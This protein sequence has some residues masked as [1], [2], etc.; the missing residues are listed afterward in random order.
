MT[1]QTLARLLHLLPRPATP[2]LNTGNWD[3]VEAT[4]RTQLPD[5]YKQLIQSY[6][7]GIIRPANC[8]FISPFHLPL[9]KTGSFR[10]C[11]EQAKKNGYE[12]PFLVYPSPGGLLPWGGGDNGEVFAWLTGSTPAS[13]DTIAFSP[14]CEGYLWLRNTST[15]KCIADLLEGSSP[16]F[17]SF[18]PKTRFLQAQTFHPI[19]VSPEQRQTVA[20]Q[21]ITYNSD[22]VS[23]RVGD[24]VTLSVPTTWVVR[25]VPVVGSAGPDTFSGYFSAERSDPDSSTGAIHLDLSFRAANVLTDAVQLRNILRAEL[26]SKWADYVTKHEEAEAEW[27]R[28]VGLEDDRA[29][30]TRQADLGNRQLIIAKEGELQGTSFRI[31]WLLF[32]KYKH[33]WTFVYFFSHQGE[34]RLTFHLTLIDPTTSRPLLDRIADSVLFL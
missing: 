7:A 2:V 26:E 22:M 31:P 16:L 32:S 23:F 30:G 17:P 8:W 34:W 1:R 28:E 29:K 4:L 15:V 20:L 3:E 5:D 25:T 18:F 33:S 14:N 19:V 12:I 27:Y 11:I 10:K 24:R 21:Q 13:W 6:G 9:L